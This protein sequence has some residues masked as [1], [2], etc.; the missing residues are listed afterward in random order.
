MWRRPACSLCRCMLRSVATLHF[1]GGRGR[2]RPGSARSASAWCRRP[3]AR[4]KTSWLHFHLVARRSFLHCESG[5][6]VH[7]D[8]ERW[9]NTGSLDSVAWIAWIAWID[10]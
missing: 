1:S 6:H 10:I 3:A 5:L 2:P 4:G 9:K 7:H 8:F